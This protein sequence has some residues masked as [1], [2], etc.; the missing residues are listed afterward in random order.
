MT[1]EIYI[2]GALL[3]LFSVIDLKWKSLPSVLLT[4][5]LLVLA[6][7]N[8]ANIQF[9]IL[10]GLFA[11]LLSDFGED[12]HMPF[13]NADAKI[14]IMLGFMIASLYNFIIFLACF[15]VFQF[16]YIGLMRKTLYKKGEIPFIPCLFFIY[17]ALAMAGVVA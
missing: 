10:A 9:A 4:G 11:L 13:G 12:I 7:V 16:C 3:F 2:V 14:L 1:V 5:T 8:Y 15:A 6:V 17:I